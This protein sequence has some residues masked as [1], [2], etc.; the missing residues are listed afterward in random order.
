MKKTCCNFECHQGRD[1]P[2]DRPGDSAFIGLVIVIASAAAM[3]TPFIY[4]V[5]G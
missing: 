5:W 4:Y 1:C 2:M 3:V